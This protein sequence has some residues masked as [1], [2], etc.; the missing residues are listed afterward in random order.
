MVIFVLVF[1]VAIAVTIVK[2]ATTRNM[3]LKKGADPTEATVMAL[4]GDVGTAATFLKPD[5]PTSPHQPTVEERIRKVH[6]L[7]AQGLITSEQA[8]ERIATILSEI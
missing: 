7:E 3:A 6:D 2:F 4:S 5:Q 8:K 1:I